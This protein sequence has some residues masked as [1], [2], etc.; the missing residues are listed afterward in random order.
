MDCAEAVIYDLVRRIGVVIV[1]EGQGEQAG[2]VQVVE[3]QEKEA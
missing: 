3:I 2:K 1:D